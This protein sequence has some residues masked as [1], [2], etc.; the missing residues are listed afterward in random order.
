MIIFDY[1][2]LAIANMDF[3]T[4][5]NYLWKNL[6]SLLEWALEGGDF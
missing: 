2:G 1:K 3:T 6:Q 4:W 5:V